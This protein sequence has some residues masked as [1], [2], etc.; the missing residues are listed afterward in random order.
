MVAYIV[1]ALALFD[2]LPIYINVFLV[3]AFV[4]YLSQKGRVSTEKTQ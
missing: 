3:A 2:V 1:Q 4:A